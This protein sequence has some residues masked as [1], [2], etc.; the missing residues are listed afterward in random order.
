MIDLGSA[1]R[2]ENEHIK[3]LRAALN[4]CNKNLAAA[5]LGLTLDPVP[6]PPDG[7]PHL[8]QVDK[9]KYKLALYAVG[10][11]LL[12]LLDHDLPLTPAQSTADAGSATSS[13]SARYPFDME[14]LGQFPEQRP[15]F[16]LGVPRTGTTAL[17]NALRAGGNFFGWSE[18]HLFAALPLLLA[19]MAT[20]WHEV[21][22]FD[23]PDREFYAI[24]RL[25]INSI[26]NGVVVGFNRVY[27]DAAAASGGR[28]WLDKTPN[29]R[30]I[31]A[32]PL[33]RHIY[34]DARYVFMHRHPLKQIMSF[35]RKFPGQPMEF[36]ALLWCLGMKAWSSVR[37]CL[38]PDS[39]LEL[40]QPDLSLQTPMVGEKLARLLELTREQTA[41]VQEIL[42]RDRPQHTGSSDDAAE[43]YLDDLDW[44]DVLKCW[45][46]HVAADTAQAWG[47][48]LDAPPRADGRAA[49]ASPELP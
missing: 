26:L 27:A 9:E 22:S 18:G 46:R 14:H 17:A 48:H 8:S 3:A 10:R 5:S 19:G 2:D 33:L 21:L 30:S 7:Y 29:V 31:L 25:D 40:R 24:E 42:Q 4:G 45:L 20:A 15:I 12:G 28:R 6:S 32:V 34:P 35:V 49:P 39:F 47:Y 37:D 44:P 38:A 13:K 1:E 16:V 41:A 43:I 23:L 36:A 11:R